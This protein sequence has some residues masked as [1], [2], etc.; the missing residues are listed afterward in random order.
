MTSEF[1]TY[2]VA[3]GVA[4]ITFNRPDKFNSFVREMALATQAALDKAGADPAV[5][6][7]YITGNGKAFHAGQDLGE[8]IDNTGPGLPNIVREHY[9]PVIERLRSTKT[10]HRE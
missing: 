2:S 7:I 9:N 1:L 4:S 5:R 8:A 3:D 10:G 6:C